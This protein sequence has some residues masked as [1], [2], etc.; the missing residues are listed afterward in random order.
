MSGTSSPTFEGRSYENPALQPELISNIA[1]FAAYPSMNNHLSKSIQSNISANS[2]SEETLVEGGE[3][4]R[5]ELDSHANMIVFGKHSVILSYSGRHAEVNAF[6]PDLDKLHR[7]P[8]VDAA[9]AYDCPYSM[10][11]Y[12]LIGRN[13]LHVK[14]METNLVPPFI[15]REAGIELNDVPK[16]HV[17]HAEA[18][19][20]SIYFKEVDLRIPLSLWGIFSYFTSRKPSEKELEE[21]DK[22]FFTPDGPEWN[23]HCDSYARNEE[24]HLDWQGNIIEPKHRRTVLIEENDIEMDIMSLEMRPS[25]YGSQE[26]TA[27]D[28]IMQEAVVMSVNIE[29]PSWDNLP[30]VENEVGIQLSSVS[31]TL[32]PGTFASNLNERLAYSKFGMSVGSMNGATEID[33]DL[34]IDEPT[35][36]NIELSN[37]EANIDATHA[38]TPKGI[39]PKELAKVWRIDLETAK[40]TLEVTSQRRKHDGNSSLSRNISTNDRMLRYKRI[41]CHFFT[42]TFFVTAKGRSKRGNTCMQIFVSDKGF[43]YVVPMKSKGEFPEALKM[44]SK[45]IGVPTALIVDPAG[46]QTSQEVR[47]FCHQIGTTLRTLEENTQWAN[48]AELYIGLMKESV[49]KDMRESNCPLVLWDYCAERR[50]RIHNLTS[51][52]LFQLQGQNPHSATLGDEGDISNLC[53]Y[54]W[55]EWCYYR[56]GKS[57]FPYPKEMLGRVLGPA[58]NAGN[59]M[60]QWVLKSNGKIV[61]RRTLRK[62]RYEELNN[63]PTETQKRALFD[64][65]ITRKFGNSIRP[66]AK[67]LQPEEYDFIPYEDD[68]VEPYQVP[69]SDPVDH[70]GKPVCE[71]PLYD[72]LIHAEVTLPQGENQMNAKV[73]GRAKDDEGKMVG[74]FHDNPLLNSIVYDVE[75]PD[76]AVKQ[77]AANIIAE[78]M[79]SQVDSEG[80]QY[81]LLEAILDYGTDGNAVRK[82]NEHVVTKRGRQ[83]LRKSTA[84]WKLLV[85]W[86]GG[87]EQWIPLKDIKESNPV[88]VAEFAK[89]RGIADEPAFNWWVPFTLKKRDRIIASVNSRVKRATHKYGVEIPNTL[90]QSV[91]LDEKNGNT[92][93]QDA[94]KK[95][96]YNVSV[97]FQI[98]DHG[99]K[100]PPGWKASSGHIIFDVKM[101]FTRKARWVKDGHKTPDPDWSTYAGFVTRDSVR[102]ALTYAALNEVDVTA[103]DIKN[104]YLQAPSSEKHFVICGNEFGMEHAGKIALIR[105]ALYGGKSAGRDFWAHLRSCM[106]FLGFKSC[107]ADPDVWMRAALKSDG[108]E[109]WEYVLLYC[110]DALVISENG[111]KLLREEIGKYFELKE[112]SIGPPKIY[113]GGKLNKVTLAN[114]VN[115]WSFSSSQYVKEAVSNVESYLNE[116]GMKLANRARSPFTSNYRPEIDITK[117]L[118]PVEA[119]YYMSLIGVLRWMVE[120]GRVDICVEVSLM[121]SQM[122]LPRR[123]HL[124]Q[125]FHLFSYLKNHH[126]SE[127][128]F[129]PSEPTIDKSQFEREDWSS[130]VYGSDLTEDL[131]PHM[132]EARGQGF[133]IS[134]YVD[135][136]HAGDSLTRK[137]RTGFLVFVNCALVYWLSKKQTGIETSSFGSEFMAMKQCTEYIRG[138]KY[139]LRMMGIA[140]E[141]PA[142]VYGDNQSVL[143]NT[144]M[145][146]S[147]LKKK[148]NSIAY[149]FVREGTAKDEWRTTYVNTSSNPADLLTKPLPAGEKRTRFVQMLL[150][151]LY[152]PG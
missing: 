65:F 148:S 113:L 45:E 117:E 135:S 129:D 3:E 73:I 119:S 72:R 28:M 60:A 142:Y 56:E 109:Y 149:H 105:R 128:V 108:S 145:P 29:E 150:Y 66:P 75:F 27:I 37:M 126:N 58:K 114:G 2:G 1:H 8:I 118:G 47:K 125:L 48:R 50:A 131:P 97:A 104:A 130:T 101:D 95:E 124:D 107:K 84:G 21:C 89:S 14:S 151:H 139:K 59:E 91:K 86:K 30:L 136:D 76:G 137:S 10:K 127:M 23:P 146:H 63:N 133:V 19:D 11:T 79:Y 16:I 7:V 94:V 102:I 121:S 25:E 32:D 106:D 134:A 120:L 93:W 35:M 147:V 22:I 70:Q 41:N 141:G 111:E 144:T 24:N 152:N 78:N 103:A 55:Y 82:G 49:R 31:S 115:A 33:D 77:Y 92:L 81:N 90:E 26:N 54:E 67:P 87:T 9:I 4:S 83:R 62:L 17:P 43:V 36:G 112:E 99:E 69:E 34:F 57:K 61:P 140:C 64:E 52:S 51:K 5:T 68:E 96:M 38:E 13:A 88:E 71:Q 110:D 39:S 42:D 53:T 98:L 80:H 6:T 85:L 74:H 123:G 143:S 122:A 100:A 20:H 138:L 132:P 12:I 15:M 46:E 18:K 40:K 44:F 116:R